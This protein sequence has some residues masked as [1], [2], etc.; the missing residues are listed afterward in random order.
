MLIDF[1]TPRLLSLIFTTGHQNPSARKLFAHLQ[2]ICVFAIFYAKGPPAMQH[3]FYS[4]NTH[5]L[6]LAAQHIH[7]QKTEPCGS[8]LF[9]L[10]SKFH[11][12]SVTQIFLRFCVMECVIFLNPGFCLYLAYKFCNQHLLPWQTNSIFT[13]FLLH[14]SYTNNR[15]NP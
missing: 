12:K 8:V 14:T 10:Y 15:V 3:G 1:L 9:L 4:A 11:L 5:Q 7:H 6:L 2:F 13:I